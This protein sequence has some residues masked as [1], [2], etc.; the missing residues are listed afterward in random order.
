MSARPDLALHAPFREDVALGARY[1]QARLD[2]GLTQRQLADMTGVPQADISRI[3][4]G[5]A[6][7]TEAT[8]Q[9]LASALD[10]RLA[11]VEQSAIPVRLPGR[12]KNRPALPWSG[13]DPPLTCRFVSAMP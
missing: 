3:E 11:L 12:L 10:R 1:Q 2:R 13:L 5:A 9:R 8:L 6:T 7:P 4:R